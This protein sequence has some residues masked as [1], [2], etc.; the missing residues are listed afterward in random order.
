M[1][2][3][4]GFIFI[5]I[6]FIGCKESEQERIT[7]LVNEWSGKVIQFPDSMCLTSY[8]NDT[9][10]KKYVRERSPYTILNYVDTMGCISCRLQLLR[11][12][13]MME[14]LDSI[15]P[16]RVTCLMIFNPKGKKKMIKHLRNNQFDY[17]VYID[18][19][20]TINRLNNFLKEEE[21]CTFLLDK[22]DKIIAIGNPVLRPKIRKLYY[23]IISEETV[24]TSID[25]DFLTVISLS[26]D[27]V[28]LGSFPWD[29]KKEAE[30]IISNVGKVPL[31]INDV[32]TSCGC[33]T[34]EYS[35]KPIQIGKSLT[36]KVKYEAEHPEHF[37]KTITIYCNIKNAP[38]RLRI[39]GDAE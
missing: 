1:I 39:S 35:K 26:T 19:K 10:R 37:D 8:G 20:D 31:V 12:K 6:F 11:W 38:L 18:E 34:V 17:F 5:V 7:R 2:R 15:Y 24:L 32:I 36:L 23:D 22:N 30:F 29:T 3:L 27:K 28:D 25:K 9:V 13:E 16:N 33:I 4:I 21:L 14:E